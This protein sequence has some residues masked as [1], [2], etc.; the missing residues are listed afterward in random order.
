MTWSPDAPPVPNLQKLVDA[1]FVLVGPDGIYDGLFDLL[2]GVSNFHAV[3]LGRVEQ[4]VYVGVQAED[5]RIVIDLVGPD[6][7]KHTG[8]IVQ[9]VSSHVHS[10]LGPG[11]ELAVHPDLV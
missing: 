9:G 10:G 6:P 5:G 7:L 4:A 1:G 8:A 11:N 3:D 2:L